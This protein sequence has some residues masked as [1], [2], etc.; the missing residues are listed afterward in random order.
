MPVTG[1]NYSVINLELSLDGLL[2]KVENLDERNLLTSGLL[3]SESE[4]QDL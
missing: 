3:N 4:I 2:R 1:N